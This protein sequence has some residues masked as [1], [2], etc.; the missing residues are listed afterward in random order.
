[1][2]VTSKQQV[3]QRTCCHCVPVICRPSYSKI[4]CEF[5]NPQHLVLCGAVV[6]L[7]QLLAA[8]L[9]CCIAH[10]YLPGPYYDGRRGGA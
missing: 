2:T 8:L 10:S 9:T 5:V 4:I 7:P 6:L 1:M 3:A